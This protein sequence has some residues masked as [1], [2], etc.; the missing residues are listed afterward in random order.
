MLQAWQMTRAAMRVIVPRPVRAPRPMHAAILGRANMKRSYGKSLWAGAF[1][2]FAGVLFVGCS[3]GGDGDPDACTRADAASC[4]GKADF[5]DRTLVGLGGNGRA[6]SDC[7]MDSESFQLTPAAAQ[8]RLAQMTATG[9]DDPLFRAIDAD[10][11]RSNGAAARDF[12]NLTQNAL[13]RVTIALPANVKLLDCGA[14]VPC[15]ASARPTTETVADVWRAVPSILDTSITG[16]DGV[17][18]FWP[19][20]PNPSGG[21]QLDGPLDTLPSQAPAA[22]RSHASIGNSPPASFLDDLAAFQS[23]QFSSPGVKALSDAIKA[24]TSPLPYPDPVMIAVVTAAKT[25]CCRACAQCR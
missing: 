3:G 6:C 12:T 18:P 17:A 14:T 10:D 19:R 22:L 2:L 7:H 20:G 15:P 8:R 16:P 13:V 24:G 21:Y 25:I 9:I 4:R 1:V 5:H 23:T 11:F